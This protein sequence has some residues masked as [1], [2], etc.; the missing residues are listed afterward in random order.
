[1]FS[2]GRC[3]QVGEGDRPH[4]QLVASE[5]DERFLAAGT[6]AQPGPRGAFRDVAARSAGLPGAAPFDDESRAR[7]LAAGDLCLPCELEQVGLDRGQ[8]TDDDGYRFERAPAVIVRSAPGDPVDVR[9]EP[10]LMHQLSASRGGRPLSAFRT[11]RVSEPRES[12]A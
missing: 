10:H 3:G 5:D 11:R 7:V 9:G 6:E 12:E 4:L 1:M 2:R 8:L